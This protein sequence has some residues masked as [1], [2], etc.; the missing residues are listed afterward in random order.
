MNDIDKQLR[1]I[2]I[3]YFNNWKDCTDESN[4]I[5]ELFDIGQ[6][7]SVKS[8]D[9]SVLINSGI[10]CI[11]F[12]NRDKGHGDSSERVIALLNDYLPNAGFETTFL[13]NSYFFDFCEPLYNYWYS[14]LNF[15]DNI[16]S[17]SIVEQLLAAGFS[18]S[19]DGRGSFKITGIRDG[20][21]LPWERPQTN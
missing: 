20:F 4:F 15:E 7:L 16:K 13:G 5:S 6:R 8:V 14:Y 18:V 1:Y 12:D 9:L 3:K 2:A 19:N 10:Q 21:C 17:G 11:F